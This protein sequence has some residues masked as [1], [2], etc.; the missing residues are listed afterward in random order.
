MTTPRLLVL[1]SLVVFVLTRV[2]SIRA[3]EPR[4]TA[5]T[6][7]PPPPIIELLTGE[8]KRDYES[9]RLL[10]DNGDYASA[11]VKFHSAY[12]HSRAQNPKWEGDPRLLWNAASCEK[13]LRH[14]ARAIALVRRYLDSRSPLVTPDG[15]R[16]AQ[17]FLAAAEPLTSPL[18]I[19]ANVPGALVYLDDELL[20]KTPL[21]GSVRVDIGTHRLLVTK[22][23]H[24]D[25]AETFT[26]AGAEELRITAVLRRIQRRGVLIVRASP[27]DRIALDGVLLG[28]GR[29]E[30]TLPSGFHL[31]RV[32][33][34]GARPFEERVEVTV[35]GTRTVDVVLERDTATSE[36]PPW[37]WAA[38]GSL[39]T[40]LL[41]T[42]GYFLLGP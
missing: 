24:T 8:A 32:S 21:E 27:G 19:Q 22:G 17:A 15:A 9:A 34:P 33:A 28:I 10:Y 25:Y 42:G 20:G 23:E 3:E 36:L 4:A 31:L 11:S 41:L 26:I 12:E 29:A 39:A 16:A 6:P 7:S 40:G 38:G 14:Y 30:A 18:V 2:T 1:L 5:N 35:Q 37:V 13:N